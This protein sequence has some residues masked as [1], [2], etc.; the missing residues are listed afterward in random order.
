MQ[1]I[2]Y[3]S[4][5]WICKFVSLSQTWLGKILR[6]P[7]FQDIKFD[8]LWCGHTLH[9]LPNHCIYNKIA[10]RIMEYINARDA[11]SDTVELLHSEK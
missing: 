3:M 4:T 5:N 6:K 2:N 8:I 11:C 10:A 1:K 9:E 7:C